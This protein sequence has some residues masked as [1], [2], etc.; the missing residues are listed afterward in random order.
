M[1][2][3]RWGA[4]RKLPSGRVQASYTGPDGIRY[5]APM[6]FSDDPKRRGGTKPATAVD[7]AEAWLRGIRADIERGTWTSPDAAAAEAKRAEAERF[8]RYAE[9]WVAQRVSSKGEPLRPKTRT[10]Y[11]RQLS[12]GLAEF[13]D[14]RLTAITPARVRNWHARRRDEAG[15]TA[16][17]AEARLLRAILTTAVIDGIITANPVPGALTRTKTGRA[18][19]P[20]TI[21][22]L[23]VI[24]DN[25]G[26]FFRLAVLLSAYGG[27]RAGEWRALR[28]RDVSI[29]D[30]RA[31]IRVERAAQFLPRQ[32]WIV[33]PPKSAEG[34]RTVPLPSGLTGDVERHLSA[35][36][37][38]FPDDLIFPPIGGEGFVHDRQFNAVWNPA[39][40]AAGLR[41]P[42]RWD[43][44][45]RPT[46]WESTVRE[47]DLRAFAGT[48]FAQ[49]GATLRETMAFLGHASTTA[50]MAYQATTGREADIADRMPL[51]PTN[52]KRAANLETKTNA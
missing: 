26:P 23:A 28:R 13:A 47:H 10:E 29:V 36:V 35:Y 33:G 31:L 25:I 39:R 46:A 43:T 51:P 8:G 38:P 7:K 42:I 20:P 2:G 30:G 48:V 4:L 22:E 34:V 24:L 40:D 21:D 50:A 3:R 27:L 11:T 6:P 32:G 37:G 18:H 12:R 17:G 45:G 5:T 16:A 49:S 19:R 9:A 52:P 41:T 1:S 15:A 14:D 44:K